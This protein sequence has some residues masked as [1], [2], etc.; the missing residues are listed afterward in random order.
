MNVFITYRE[1][2]EILC[3]FILYIFIPRVTGHADVSRT[4]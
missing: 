4:Y 3:I 2:F 1:N